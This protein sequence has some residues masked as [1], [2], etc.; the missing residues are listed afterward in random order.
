[1]RNHG[2]LNRGYWG[3]LLAWL[4]KGVRLS[5]NLPG[6]DGR[7]LNGSLL[8]ARVAWN[9]QLTSHWS[10]LTAIGDG[11]VFALGMSPEQSA[12]CVLDLAANIRDSGVPGVL[13]LNLHPQNIAE[14]LAMHRAAR[15]VVDGGFLAW[16]IADC[17]DWFERVDRP[18]V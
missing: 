13:V 3:H 9:G 7:V 16:T 1:V 17:L 6:V 11:V 2:F 4:S 10:I 8:P 12:K 18:E 15:E 5:S 14:T